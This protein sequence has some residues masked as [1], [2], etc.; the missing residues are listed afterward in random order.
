MAK[1]APALRVAG[2]AGGTV[3]VM[4]SRDLSRRTEVEVPRLMRLGSRRKKPMMAIR[5]MKATKIS[6]SW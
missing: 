2:R 1:A 3:I 6:E 5:A 4:R